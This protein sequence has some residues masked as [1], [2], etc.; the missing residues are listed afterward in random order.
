MRFTVEN[1]GNLHIKGWP[2]F[3]LNIMNKRYSI[4]LNVNYF[5]MKMN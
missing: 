5:S 3:K 4:S 1:K 2:H